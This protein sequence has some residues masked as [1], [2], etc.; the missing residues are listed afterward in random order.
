M[1]EDQKKLKEGCHV[2]VGTPGKVSEMIKRQYLDTTNLDMLI[3]EE[4]DEIEAIGY[5]DM[6]EEILKLIPFQCQKCLF[7]PTKGKN[8]I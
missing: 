7:S 5:L 8:I 1:A 6:I 4:A 3:I 2:V